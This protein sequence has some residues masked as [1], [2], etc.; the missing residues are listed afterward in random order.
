M[1]IHLIIFNKN[2]KTHNFLLNHKLFYIVS[3]HR[4]ILVCKF[5]NKV[6]TCCL[7]LESFDYIFLYYFILNYFVITK[8]INICMFGLLSMNYKYI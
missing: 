1:Y 4:K 3:F 5:F 6:I 2:V 8:N 7:C